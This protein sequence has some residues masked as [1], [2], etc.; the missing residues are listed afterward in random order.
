[1]GEQSQLQVIA[2]IDRISEPIH[3]NIYCPNC[4]AFAGRIG[5]D[6]SLSDYT[7]FCPDCEVEITGISAVFAPDSYFRE[8]EDAPPEDECKSVVTAY[9]NSLLSGGPNLM[10]EEEGQ[11]GAESIDIV[12]QGAMAADALEQLADEYGWDWQPE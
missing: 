3:G 6:G 2:G 1:M 10:I 11:D 4:A 8:H 9:W 12:D 5:L 7:V